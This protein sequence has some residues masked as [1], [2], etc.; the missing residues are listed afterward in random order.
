LGGLSVQFSRLDIYGQVS[1]DED[2][3]QLQIG[4]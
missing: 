3:K 2:C 1:V 4:T